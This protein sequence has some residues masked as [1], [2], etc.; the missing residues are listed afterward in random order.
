MSS[1]L[2]LPSSGLVLAQ[3]VDAFDLRRWDPDGVL[4][5]R[6]GSAARFF[7]GE[8]VGTDAEANLF[9]AAGVALIESELVPR[10]LLRGA[11]LPDAAAEIFA[12]VP[13]GELLG[14]A[15]MRLAA[16]WDELAGALRRTCPPI[17]SQRLAWLACLQLVTAD[18]AVRL[19]GLLWLT[20]PSLDDAPDLA[21]ARPNGLRDRLRD[22]QARTG[23]SR[24]RLAEQ[25][26]VGPH[27]LDGWLD[28]EVRPKDE[29]LQ[30][31]ANTFAEH[32]LGERGELLAELRRG[33]GLRELFA[34]LSGA[35]GPQHA[36]HIA[37]RVVGYAAHMLQLPRVSQNAP[38]EI[39]R[40]M[41]LALTIGTLGRDGMELGFVESMLNSVWRIEEDPVWRTSL[42]AATRS[43]FDRMVDVTTRLPP[44]DV[45]GVAALLGD[46]PSQEKLALERL[47]DIKAAIATYEELL[48]MKR[49]HAEALD[50]LAHLYFV[51]GDKRRGAALAKDA[52]H[53]GFTDVF[54]AWSSKYYDGKQVRG[55]PPR[56]TARHLVQLGEHAWLAEPGE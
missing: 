13:H 49:D 23:L 30:D 53:L 39:D 46:L 50:R 14:A 54:D 38:A 17:F 44:E 15:L 36:K 12:R 37:E 26:R 32:G 27:T 52:A 56:T 51:I 33:Y 2:S 21:W 28:D 7:G 48:A 43:W 41:N 40:K 8:R 10:V 5:R 20:R 9:G 19:T 42:K 45:A 35:V 24:D 11:P 22:Q 47:G 3:L 34:A 31:L 4:S 16:R 6:N 29:N 18:L 55:R 1:N 25:L